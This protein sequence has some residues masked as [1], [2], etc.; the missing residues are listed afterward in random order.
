MRWKGSER[1]Q[2]L[3]SKYYP[4]IC[5]GAGWG[6][7]RKFCQNKWCLGRGSNGELPEYVS[8]TLLLTS[9]SVRQEG[10]WGSECIAPHF[11]DVGSIWRWVV[12]FTPRPSC[13]KGE[14]SPSILWIGGWVGPRSGLD[15]VEQRIFLTLPGLEIR[16]PGRKARSQSLYRLCY[17]GSPRIFTEERVF[18]FV[19]RWLAVF[20]CSLSSFCLSSKRIFLLRIHIHYRLKCDVYFL[21]HVYLNTTRFDLIR[22]AIFRYMRVLLYFFCHTLYSPLI[23]EMIYS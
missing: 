9:F 10:V 6:K 18:S 22:R 15:D 23:F 17:L 14:W 2:L 20:L 7:P 12:S 16:P 8:G 1:K 21:A 11:L 5:L 13:Q 3:E 4:R 19:V